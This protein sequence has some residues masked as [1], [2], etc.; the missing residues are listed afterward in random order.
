MLESNRVNAGGDQVGTRRLVGAL[1]GFLLGQLAGDKAVT[2][3][4]VVLAIFA[5]EQLD[6]RH[7]VA[8]ASL[9]VILV[10]TGVSAA[11][12]LL[13]VRRRW[14]Y[15]EA[16]LLAVFVGV[17]TAA[18]VVVDYSLPVATK[19]SD[20]LVGQPLYFL[21]WIL[22]LWFLP[23][24][25]L[26]NPDG[27]LEGRVLRG[28]GALAV[29]APMTIIGLVTGFVAEIGWGSSEKFWIAKPLGINAICGSL[30][31]VAC[32]NIWWR[33]LEW[34]ARRS[35][36]WTVGITVVASA[37]AGLWGLRLYE[38]NA[39]ADWR[40]FLGFGALPVVGVAAVYL[41]YA[42]TRRVAGAAAVG[43]PVSK[44]FWLLL[45]ITF[46]LTCSANAVVGLAPIEEY[47]GRRLVVLAW[48]HGINGAVMGVSLAA[49]LGL[50]ALIPESVREVRNKSAPG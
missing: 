11:V 13:A 43:W 35:W 17:F 9:F 26:P 34:S 10:V 27:T 36:A 1:V 49:T 42:M 20:L 47:E 22:G 16:F 48:A 2:I 28:L 12:G 32:A 29:V 38:P 18:L 31:V 44:W 8:E 50:F 14:V 24:L 33:G 45:P 6:L 30:V 39:S 37:Y 4:R 3:A 5:R 19:N 46:A 7:R 41:A 40:H 25:A 23:S 21:G 15:A